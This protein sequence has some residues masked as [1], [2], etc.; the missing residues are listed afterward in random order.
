MQTALG[1][2]NRIPS[3]TVNWNTGYAWNLAFY[4]GNNKGAVM[5]VGRSATAVYNLSCYNVHTTAESDLSRNVSIG[6]LL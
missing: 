6:Q 5:Y 2:G 4:K 1:S 3:I